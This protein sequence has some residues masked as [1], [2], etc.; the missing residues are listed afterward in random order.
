MKVP[1]QSSQDNQQPVHVTP[2]E[3]QDMMTPNDNLEN[4]AQCQ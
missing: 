4:T 2:Y 3:H 1:L